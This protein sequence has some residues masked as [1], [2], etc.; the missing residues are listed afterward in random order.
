MKL[1]KFITKLISKNTSDAVEQFALNE[2]DKAIA[3]AKKT[4][5]GGAVASAIH[6][7]EQNGGTS[8]KK[9]ADAVAAVKPAIIDYLKRGGVKALEADAEQ[10]AKQLIESTLADLKQTKAVTI[11]RAILSILGIQ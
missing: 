10:F 7:S 5:I 3:A 9:L 8:A 1:P 4:T 11:G 6:V 2:L